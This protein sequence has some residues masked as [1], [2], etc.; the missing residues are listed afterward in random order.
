MNE[1]SLRY[2]SFLVKE[3][4]QDADA[5]PAMRRQDSA[6]RRHASAHRVIISSSPRASQLN[7]QASQASAHTPQT[8]VCS[9]EPRSMKPELVAQI[10]EQ[11]MSVRM[12][13]D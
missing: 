11:S 5:I 13:S 9:S 6:Q 4:F 7:A 3:L 1:G 2:R 12:W 8:S 10:S